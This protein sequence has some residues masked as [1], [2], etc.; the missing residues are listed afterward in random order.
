MTFVVTS[1]IWYI[2]T[3]FISTVHVKNWMIKFK[4]VIFLDNT[5]CFNFFPS[6]LNPVN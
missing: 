2:L 6:K 5:F 1:S 4:K 3:K